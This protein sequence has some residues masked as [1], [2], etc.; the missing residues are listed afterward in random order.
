VDAI[1][2]ANKTEYGIGDGVIFVMPILDA[3]RVRTGESGEAAI[4]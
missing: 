4:W 3:I 2:Q 1:T